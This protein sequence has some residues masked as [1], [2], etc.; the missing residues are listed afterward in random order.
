MT[1]SPLK[2]SPRPVQVPGQ[3]DFWEPGLDTSVFKAWHQ[4]AVK[5][6]VQRGGGKCKSSGKTNVLSKVPSRQTLIGR[7]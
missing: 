1:R 5:D 3:A 2:Y 6:S 7:A 4:E